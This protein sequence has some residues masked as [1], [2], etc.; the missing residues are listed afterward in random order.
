MDVIYFILQLAIA[1]TIPLA[2]VAFGA[3]FSERS[4]VVNIALEGIMLMGAFTGAWFMQ[5]I[6]P[7]GY[8]PQIIAIMGLGVGALTGLVYSFFHA[9]ASIHMRSNQIISA[10]A[11][12]MF[13]AAFTVFIARTY[14]VRQTK[15][16]ALSLTYKIPEVPILSKIPIIG[17]ILFKQAFISTYIG[18]AI[19]IISGIVLY[20]TKFGLRLRSCGE[21]PQAADSLGVNI[22][23]IRYMGVLISGAFA[24]MGGVIFV[25]SFANAFDGSVF[26]F[27]FLSLSVLIFGQ[28]KPV[29]I[30]LAAVFFGFMRVISSAYYAIDFLVEL[31]LP[32]EI[33]AM[34][35]Y[36]ATM[37]VLVFVSKNSAAPIAAGIPYDPGRR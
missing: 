6:E 34:I 17:D 26:G 21:N 8:H 35:P 11:L 5:S 18:I 28:W 3:L 20:K 2:L 36:I 33:Y 4:G 10:T 27:G 22:Y 25:L 9:F 19:F 12:N 15:K 32:K 29:R 16:I 14:T 23:F 13:A 37:I 24:G 31:D 30:L 1:S 7:L